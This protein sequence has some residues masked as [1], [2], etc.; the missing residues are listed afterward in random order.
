MKYQLLI[1][2]L[3][4]SLLSCGG[5]S[6]G[7]AVGT[8]SG[9]KVTNFSGIVLSQDGNGVAFTPVALLNTED[10][11]VTDEAGSF[12][13]TSEFN[14]GDAAF[15]IGEGALD[16]VVV[17][18]NLPENAQQVELSILFNS[19][20]ET[21]SLLSLTLRARIVRDCNAFF[22]NTRT[23]RQTT[24]LAEGVQC[25]VEVEIKSD[26]VPVD[27]LLFEL[28]HRGCSVNAPWQ[29]SGVSKTGSSGPGIGE[30]TFPFRN[31]EKHC[32][33]RIIGP[34][35]RRDTIAVSAQIQTLRKQEFDS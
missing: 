20:S 24:P 35:N 33:Y 29:F 13:L 18:E 17:V 21:A 15:A 28:Q 9:K 19:D 22:L 31:D 16:T 25:T 11:T 5:G 2:F 3:V 7:T 14:G 30:L 10:I 1:F 26:G 23:I 4:T 27:D 32:V 12:E 34:L 6:S 8:P